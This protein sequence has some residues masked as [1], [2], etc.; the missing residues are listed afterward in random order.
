MKY[1]TVSLLVLFMVGIM[2][3]NAFAENVPDWVKDDLYKGRTGE[4][5]ATETIQKF[6]EIGQRSIFLLPSITDG[7]KRDYKL[8][9]RVIEKFR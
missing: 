6:I 8:A 2:L 5:L 4:D 7:G 9:Q 3:P 1:I